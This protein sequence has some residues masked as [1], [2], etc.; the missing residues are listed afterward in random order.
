VQC[1]GCKVAPITGIRY[2]C[3]VCEDFD[4]CAKCEENLGH[5]HPFLKIRKAGGA[6]TMMMTVLNEEEPRHEERK[7]KHCGG[8][9]K[10]EWKQMKEQWMAANP[11]WKELMEQW[12][13]GAEEKPEWKK[14]KEQFKAMKEKPEWKAMKE[15]WMAA[16]PNWKELKEQ[17]TQGAEKPEWKKMKEQMRQE[18]GGCHGGRGAWKQMIGG[19]LEKMGVDCKGENPW[20]FMDGARAGGHCHGKGQGIHKMKRATV[21]SNPDT[22]LECQ[23]GQVVLHDIEIKN[24]THWAWKQGVFLGMDESTDIAG[25][26]IEVVNVPVDSKVD[27]METLKMSVP[28][29]VAENAFITD[30]V[31]EFKLR[32]RGPHGNEFGEPIPLKLKVVDFKKPAVVEKPAPVKMSQVE[33]VKLAVKLFDVQKLGQ[34]FDECLGVVTEFN[35]NEEAA[36]KRLQPR[37]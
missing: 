21:V 1:D 2:K 19:F 27:A 17:W 37:Q 13:Q 25:M 23:P 35:G 8:K 26:P 34:T 24:N 5:D 22:V 30:Q 15:Q 3:A 20:K 28:I 10:P 14:M 36:I 18:K 4:Y 11:N 7:Q 6:P 16:N 31:F 12:K 9:N 32:F 33:L 29:T